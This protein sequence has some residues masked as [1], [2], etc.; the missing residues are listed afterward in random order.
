MSTKT[1][2]LTLAG[3]GLRFDAVAGSG[4]GLV[5]DDVRQGPVAG[6]PPRMQRGAA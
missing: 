5:L 2:T 6:P 1:A 3:D 4:H